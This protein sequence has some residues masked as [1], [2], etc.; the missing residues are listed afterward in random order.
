MQNA[1]NGSCKKLD[2]KLKKLDVIVSL[3]D[4][5]MFLEMVGVVSGLWENNINFRGG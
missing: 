4:D 5:P 2:D 1:L 3:Q